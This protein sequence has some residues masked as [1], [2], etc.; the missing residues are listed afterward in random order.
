MTHSAGVSLRDSPSLRKLRPSRAPSTGEGAS[1]THGPP[2]A[3]GRQINS[4]L[5]VQ[6]AEAPPTQIRRLAANRT[7]PVATIHGPLPIRCMVTKLRTSSVVVRAQDE[8]REGGTNL[9][10][11]SWPNPDEIRWSPM[12]LALGGNHNVRYFWAIIVATYN[13]CSENPD[14]F[15]RQWAAN[16]IGPSGN[17]TRITPDPLHGCH[18]MNK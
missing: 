6:T 10:A 18:L 13:Y 1:D 16:R 4:S 15:G 11:R 14:K 3:P 17:H 9:D 2:R 7:G 8:I 5:P 12:A